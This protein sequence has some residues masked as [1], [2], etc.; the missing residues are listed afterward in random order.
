M[1]IFSKALRY[2][3]LANK[4]YS[5]SNITNFSTTDA[6]KLTTISYQM[7]ALLFMPL[8]F[9]IALFL[10]YYF[11][12]VSFLSGIAVMILAILINFFLQRIALRL[13]EKLLKA[14]DGR[15]KVTE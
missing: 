10:M 9:T 1:L 5:S 15:M 12:G 8:Q 4:L 11:I 13:N 7:T 3:I 14:K 6:Q 2:P